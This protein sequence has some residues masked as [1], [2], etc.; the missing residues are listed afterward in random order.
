MDM[1]ENQIIIK[2]IEDFEPLFNYIQNFDYIAFDTETTGLYHGAEVIGISICAESDIAFYVV[3]SYWCVEQKKLI[4]LDTCLKMCEFLHILKTKKLIAHNAIFDCSKLYDIYRIDLMPSVYCDTMILSHTLNEERSNKLKDLGASVYGESALEE[5]TAM[6]ASVHQNGGSL[7]KKCHEMYKADPDLL[8]MYGAKDALLTLN[9]FY[10]FIPQLM[11]QGLDKFFFDDECMPLLRG[12]TYD[13]NTTG[14]KVDI[15]KLQELKGSLEVEIAASGAFI[16]NEIKDLVKDKYPGAKKTNM[17]NINSNQ[18]LAWLLFERLNNDFPSLTD[19]G[20]ALCK[21]LHLNPYTI[22]DRKTFISTCK[23]FKG[24]PWNSRKIGD[25]WQYMSANA[26]SLSIFEDKYAWI[27]KLLE[28][29]KNQKILSTYVIGIQEKIEYG[30]IRPRFNQ[31]GTT[32]GRYSSND[33]NFQN[34]PRDDKRIKSCIVSRPGKVFVGADYSQLEPRVFASISQDPRLLECFAKGEDFYSVVGA[35]IFGIE[36]LSMFKDDPNSFAIK[37]KV[38]RQI[39]KSFAL[40]TAYGTTASK[41]AKVLS[42][43]VDECK[44]IIDKY[45]ASYPNVE[46]MM[47]DAHEQA[48]NTGIVYGLYGRPRR[49]PEAMKIPK[50]INHGELPYESRNLL[51]LAMNHIVQSTAASIVNRAAIAFCGVVK[52]L[53]LDA[54]IVLQVHDSLVIECPESDASQVSVILKDCMELTTILPGVTLIAEPEI[55]NSLADLK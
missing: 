1:K 51:N 32:S 47:L 26:D 29:K 33:P 5:Q 34:L 25:P 19:T 38:L 14:L 22:K 45:F 15:Q 52:E 50:G 16:A 44:G 9:L 54:K 18:Q 40:A 48:K 10:E 7:T 41:Q 37:H 43:T 17:F 35:P 24:Q 3:L 8:G 42:K 28:Q 23:D 6:K 27:K 20:L 53:G 13:M 11:A 31:S 49:I 21:F 2:T 36:G 12:P 46:H 4:E 55:A 30:I 39:A